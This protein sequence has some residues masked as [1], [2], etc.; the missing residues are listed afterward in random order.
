MAYKGYFKQGV[1][2]FGFNIIT[3]L[4]FFPI[5]L[6]ALYYSLYVDNKVNN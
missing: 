4:L 5:I 3:I 1:K 2:D 6:T